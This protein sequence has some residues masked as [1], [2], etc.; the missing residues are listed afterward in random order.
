MPHRIHPAGPLALAFILLVLLPGRAAAAPRSAGAMDVINAVNALRATYGLPAYA[1]D[2]GLM[3]FSQSH[4]DYQASIGFPTHQ[5][6]DGTYPDAHGVYE[7]VAV[8]SGFNLDFVMNTVWSDAIH[9]TTMVGIPT[10]YIG[11]GIA[12]GSDGDTYYTIDVRKT[13]GQVGLPERPVTAGDS[14]ASANQTPFATAPP[15]APLM[16]AT[17]R[18][19]GFLVHT[20]GY[21]QTLWDIALAYGVHIDNLRALNSIPDGSVAIYTGQKLLI[22]VPLP[23]TATAAVKTAL[24]APAASQMAATGTAQ[25]LTPAPSAT[26][27]RTPRPPTRTPPPTRTT[28]PQPRATSTPAAPIVQLP[29][30]RTFGMGLIVACGLGLLALALTGFK[31]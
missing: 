9:M 3:A 19:N 25:A 27:T 24:A 15:I 6:K 18:A 29:N 31:K 17:P 22:R 12:T 10:G 4:S 30:S 1:V 11:A 23:S 13:S 26:A 5:H 7:N 16:T 2:G 21:G 28:A 14:A 20:V 8:T